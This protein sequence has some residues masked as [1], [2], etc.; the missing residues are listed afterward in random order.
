[1]AGISTCSSLVSADPS[2]RAYVCWLLCA[3]AFH[4]GPS[5][6]HASEQGSVFWGMEAI[7]LIRNQESGRQFWQT[8]FSHGMLCHADLAYIMFGKCSGIPIGAVWLPCPLCS[9]LGNPCLQQSKLAAGDPGTHK[10]IVW[11]VARQHPGES[12]AEWFMEGFLDEL[13]DTHNAFSNRALKHAIFYVVPNINPDGAIRGH[14]R[15]NAVGANLNRE[16]ANPTMEHSPEVT[17]ITIPC[18]VAAPKTQMSG[19]S[20]DQHPLVCTQKG[21]GLQSSGCHN[22]SMSEFSFWDNEEG[23]RELRRLLFHVEYLE[24]VW[25]NDACKISFS[26]ELLARLLPPCLQ[27]KL[28][29]DRMEKTDCDFFLD[30]SNLSDSMPV[31]L[32]TLLLAHAMPSGVMTLSHVDDQYN[33]DRFP[34]QR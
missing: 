7:Q 2:S 15:T 12:M 23:R 16:W 22:A 29:K 3:N 20:A 28:V 32:N 1:M 14:L 25:C 11:I 30:V 21:L 31:L 19:E 27:V 6:L 34:C 9:C 18:Q 17:C 5:L 8:R 24:Q 33:L 10:K 26:V 13:T 4:A